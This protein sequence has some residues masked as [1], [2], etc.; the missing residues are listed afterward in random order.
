[1]VTINDGVSIGILMLNTTFPRFKGDIGNKDTFAFPVVQQ[2]VQEANS[3]NVVLRTDKHLISA[4]IEAAEILENKGVKAI[5]TSCGFLSAFQKE[6]SNAVK[7][8]VATSVLLLL[9]L[10]S[11]IIGNKRVG[12]LTANSSSLNAQHF[13][14]CN[15][16]GVLTVIKGMEG[17][18]FFKMY[19]EGNNSADTSIMEDEIYRIAVEMIEENDDIGA[20]LLECTNM[21][22]FSAKLRR[23]GL[24]IFDIRTLVTLLYSGVSYDV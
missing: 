18:E 22:P 4:F 7:I 12:I 6:L 23:F 11:N 13:R 20:I 21:P 3:S 5:T 8:P 15:A 16:S 1:M 17:T 24:P 2:V 14:A 9:P 19:V 10:I